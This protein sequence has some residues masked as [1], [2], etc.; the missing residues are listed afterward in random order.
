MLALAAW[1]VRGGS[2]T[3]GDFVLVNQFMLQL[4]MPLGFLGFVYREIKS[5][6]ANIEKLFAP[7]RGA[8]R[9]ADA[10]CAG[11]RASN[12][13]W[14]FATSASPTAGATDPAR[15]QFAHWRR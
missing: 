13:P 5:S 11:P 14:N 15:R 10:R 4:F 6:L 1:Q 9:V 12:R 3:L 7:P 2:M 8:P